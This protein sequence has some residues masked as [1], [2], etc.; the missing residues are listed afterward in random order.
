MLSRYFMVLDPHPFLAD[1][2]DLLNDLISNHQLQHFY[3]AR[4]AEKGS[5]SEHDHIM[6]VFED[7][8]DEFSVREICQKVDHRFCVNALSI[9]PVKFL[10][11]VHFGKHKVKFSSNDDN[12]YWNE[13]YD[14][15]LDT[16]D[17]RKGH[18]SH[19]Y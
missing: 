1:Q 7:L 17:F 11:Y 14:R 18:G 12:F 6:F 10:Q 13:L 3:I 5:V 9:N 8:R 4:H 2:I 16:F 19:A 15:A